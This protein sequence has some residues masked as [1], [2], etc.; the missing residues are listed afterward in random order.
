MSEPNIELA[1]VR[2]A[3]VISTKFFTLSQIC[4]SASFVGQGA[5]LLYRPRTPLRH[6]TQSVHQGEAS[7]QD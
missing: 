1:A 3:R 5:L 7:H 4:V 2:S 6:R